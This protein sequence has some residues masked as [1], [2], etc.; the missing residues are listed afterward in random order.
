MVWRDWDLDYIKLKLQMGEDKDD[1]IDTLI[2]LL[3]QM[4]EKRDD[5]YT[6][7][8]EV[9]DGFV[10]GAYIKDYLQKVLDRMVN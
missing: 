2:F 5:T 3:E 7:I 8:E 1:C 10:D 6:D 9:V 4:E